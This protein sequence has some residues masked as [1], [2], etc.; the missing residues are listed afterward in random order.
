MCMCMKRLEENMKNTHLEE[1]MKN[2]HLEENM[3]NNAFLE[4]PLDI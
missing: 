2:T 1:N 4:H 3:K